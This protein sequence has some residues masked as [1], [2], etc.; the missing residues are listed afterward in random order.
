[1]GHIKIT[2]NLPESF[3]IWISGGRMFENNLLQK[4][5]NLDERYGDAFEHSLSNRLLPDP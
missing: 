2:S 4:P 5:E 1:M 3:P